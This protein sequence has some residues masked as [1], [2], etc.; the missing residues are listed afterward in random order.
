MGS[1]GCVVKVIIWHKYQLICVPQWC[2]LLFGE[3]MS[4]QQAKASIMHRQKPYCEAAER[5]KKLAMRE[6]STYND[7]NLSLEKRLTWRGNN[8]FE[9]VWCQRIFMVLQQAIS[10]S[11]SITNILTTWG[12]IYTITGE[13]NQ[14]PPPF[15][16][17]LPP[18]R[19]KSSIV[20]LLT[21]ALC[22]ARTLTFKWPA[23]HGLTLRVL[24]KVTFSRDGHT[25]KSYLFNL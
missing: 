22:A 18:G 17:I 8:I 12:G 2:Y 7:V 10:T 9:I 4:T 23:S 15:S 13:G 11:D 20:S 19:F 16:P 24:N 1:A 5:F 3:S 14:L 25:G 21:K 6:Y